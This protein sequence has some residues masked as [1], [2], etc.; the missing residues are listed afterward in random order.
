MVGGGHGLV[1][2]S[3]LVPGPPTV[4]RAVI[5]GDLVQSRDF[6]YSVEPTPVYRRPREVAYHSPGQQVIPILLLLYCVVH[7]RSVWSVK[8]VYWV[9]SKGFE[10]YY[11]I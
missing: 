2:G 5:S 11:K 7:N 1:P 4:P 3:H 6:H 8:V 9:L 10:Y